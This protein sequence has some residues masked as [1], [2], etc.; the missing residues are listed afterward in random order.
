M[1]LRIN[2]A[3]E[4]DVAGVR[5]GPAYLPRGRYA[6]PDLVDSEPLGLRLAW[7]PAAGLGRRRD[8]VLVSR[9][10]RAVLRSTHP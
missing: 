7:V 6:E 4:P 10:S 1:R 8:P 5:V 9:A 3:L 2:P